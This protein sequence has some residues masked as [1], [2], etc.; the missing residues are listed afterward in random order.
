[1]PTCRCL[2]YSCAGVADACACKRLLRPCWL[3][4]L[5]CPRLL[6]LLLL[7]WCI[8]QGCCDCCCKHGVFVISLQSM[9]DSRA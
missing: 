9:Q 7:A 1:V 2:S 5:R 3:R 8:L 4:R 6:L